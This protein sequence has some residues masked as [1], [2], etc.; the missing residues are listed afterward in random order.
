M[1]PEEVIAVSGEV[2][3]RL[4]MSGG[5]LEREAA[6][7]EL[8]NVKPMTKLR[9]ERY[10]W[11]RQGMVELLSVT[12]RTDELRSG[13]FKGDSVSSGGVRKEREGGAWQRG[14]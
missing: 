10:L 3:K 1:S 6:P 13:D 7:G 12:V 11:S 4:V 8:G 2:P 9:R 14:L 5:G